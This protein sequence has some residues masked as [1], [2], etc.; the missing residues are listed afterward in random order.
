MLVAAEG[1]AALVFGLL[2]IG[3]VQPGR[4]M[5]GVGVAIVMLAYAALLMATA[6]GLWRG[7]RWSRAPTVVTQLILLPVALSFR[8]GGTDWVSVV[9]T[10]VAIPAL[11]AVLLPRST[12]Y[13]VPDAGG[14]EH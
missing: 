1:V 12:R 5:V 14:A 10:A 9:I 11:V 2:Q 6:R 13:L 3:G 4:A 7:R 8:G